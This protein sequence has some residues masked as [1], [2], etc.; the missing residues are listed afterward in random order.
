M[1]CL[2]RHGKREAAANG[3]GAAEVAILDA[4]NET[5]SPSGNRTNGFQ[6]WC[7][8]GLQTV[9]NDPDLV[10]GQVVRLQEGS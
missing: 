8:H 6:A 3:G 7:S 5:G 4:L 9:E 10:P 2:F 1:L